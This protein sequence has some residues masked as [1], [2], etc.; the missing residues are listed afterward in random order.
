M[1]QL[2]FPS[3]S[4]WSHVPLPY[5]IKRIRFLVLKR[6][7]GVLVKRVDFGAGMSVFKLWACNLLAVTF[8]KLLAD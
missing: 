6:Q 3:F 8:G 2:K 7:C 4:Q 1:T 5:G